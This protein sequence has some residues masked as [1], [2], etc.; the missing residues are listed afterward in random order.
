MLYRP[1]S[2]GVVVDLVG[3]ELRAVVEVGGVWRPVA[4]ARAWGELVALAREE[5]SPWA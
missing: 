1:R 2:V 5:L 3:G 4:V